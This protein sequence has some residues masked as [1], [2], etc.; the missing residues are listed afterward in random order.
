MQ[1]ER[2]EELAQLLCVKP[3]RL[4]S[5]SS[6][7]LSS[8]SILARSSWSHSPEILLR[9]RL[10][11]RDCSTVRSRKMT[12]TVFQPRRRAA[13][14]RWWPPMT[15][16]SSRRAS[17]GWTKSNC[18]RLRVSAFISSFPMVRGL[19]GSGCRES[20]ATFSIFISVLVVVISGL[21]SSAHSLSISAR[22]DSISSYKPA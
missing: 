9:A 19:A 10:R 22:R 6:T 14:R 18:L 13:T 1:V 15:M 4:R 20:I 3:L 11:R 17:T 2:L 7:G 21:L 5:M 12:G 8:A 16:L